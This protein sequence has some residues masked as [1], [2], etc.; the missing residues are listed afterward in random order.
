MA[1]I[2]KI[3]KSMWIVVV[4]IALGVG[5]FIL[6]DMTSGQ[7]SLFGGTPTSIGQVNGEKIDW[8]N[9]ARTDEII[10]SVLYRNSAREV[11]SRRD[12]LWSY[13]VEEI[14]IKQEA[15]KLGLGVSKTELLDLE[16][17]ITPS[18]VIQQRFSD[19]NTGQI[20][21]ERLNQFKTA[22]ES[23]QL[24][25]PLV[26]AYWAHQEKEIIKDRLQKKLINMVTKAIYVPTWMADMGYREQNDRVS[27][28][29][30]RVPFDELDNSEVALEDKDFQDYINENAEN[31]R[32]TEETRVIKYVVFN[33]FPTREDSAKV[34]QKIADLLPEFEATKEDSVFVN[35]YVGVFDPA[36]FKKDDLS[37]AIAD[38]V[39]NLPIGSVY[40][41]YIDENAYKLVKILD[42]KVI[43][44]SVRSRHILIPAED[45][46][47][48]ISAKSRVDSLKG[49]IE[50]GTHTFDSLAKVF[51]TDATASK[52]G[53]LDFAAPGQMVKPFND[54][55]FFEAEPRK[56][57][58]VQ[59]QFGWHL[60]EVTDRKF[61]KNEQGVKLAYLQE[62]IVPSQETQSSMYDRVLQFV[63]I[64]R[65]LEDLEKAVKKDASLNLETSPLLKRNDYAL[66]ADLGPS[67]TSR[68][69]IRWA[70]GAKVG[71]VSPEVYSYQNPVDLYIDKYVV[72]G[73]QAVQKAGVPSVASI[74]SLIEQSV[75]N[76]KK[77]ELLAARMKGKELTTLAQEFS[78][79]VDTAQNISFAVPMLPN[80]G[81]EP[82]VIAEA[83]SMVEGASSQPVIGNT[84]VYKFT[85]IT[86]T[87]AE[88]ATDLTLLKNTMAMTLRSQLPSGFMEALK[89]KAKIK[90]NRFTFY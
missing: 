28:A 79:T 1:L 37:P 20:D 38:T 55:I 62:A 24:T 67:V 40:G 19:P 41:P 26:R 57:Y 86:K 18:P 14:I 76:K 10:E 83:M 7:Q 70:F 21:R 48:A 80:I 42:R 44:D 16:F 43:P 56:L 9:F 54:L 30:V 27:L 69:V 60:V 22:I 31:F 81:A 17:G 8:N 58:T 87:K 90:D 49:L 68:D 35:R 52:G 25:D 2:G 13:F 61:G 51:G 59:T 65:K 50:A 64:N 73:L 45:P 4:L 47:A 72:V 5:G 82:K 78:T 23:N 3:R 36:Y 85:V 32:Q 33:V 6:Q 29:F 63:G 74:R 66:S 34:R 88:A 39:F 75:I 53:D 89:K 12:F 77:G 46:V 11:Y 15:E 71:S 84:G